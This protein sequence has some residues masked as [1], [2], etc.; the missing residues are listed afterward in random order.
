MRSS[1]TIPEFDGRRLRSARTRR[2]L[3]VAFLSLVSQHRRMPRMEDIAARSECAVRT[4]YE[5]FQ[6]IE[7]LVVDAMGVVLTKEARRRP[8][9]DFG[10]SRDERLQV[11]LNAHVGTLKRFLPLRSVIKANFGDSHEIA[12]LLE[13]HALEARDRAL[14][15]VAPELAAQS[16]ERRQ[17]TSLIAD[18]ILSAETWERLCCR[19]GLSEAEARD[20]CLAALNSII[21]ES[22]GVDG[23]PAVDWEMPL[24]APAPSASLAG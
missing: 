17:L 3:I 20:R 22:C 18:G 13:R 23:R 1:P 12:K 19:D 24:S 4:V 21:P 2:K 8:A 6:T 15:H 16:P 7:G 14:A 9:R 11:A 5:R 10:R